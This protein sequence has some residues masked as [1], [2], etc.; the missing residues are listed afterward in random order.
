MSD[1][2]KNISAMIDELES[3]KANLELQLQI[4]QAQDALEEIIPIRLE[5]NLHVFKEK[6]PNVYEFYKDYKPTGKYK[7]FCNEN[8]E[9]NIGIVEDNSSIYGSS[10]FDD[11]RK[12]IENLI[13]RMQLS[14]VSLMKEDDPFHQFHFHIKNQ[15]AD[16]ITSLIQNLPSPKK[17]ESVPFL[18]MFGLGLGY[19]LGYLYERLTPINLFI[20]EPDE[21]LFYCSLCVFDYKSLL[22]YL[23]R[24]HL[25]IHFYLRKDTNSFISNL[26]NYILKHNATILP[27]M[28]SVIYTSKAIEDFLE[29]SQRDF[30]TM[31]F[32]NGFFDD[33]LIGFW[34][35]ITNL[36]NGIPLLL[37][38]K[39]PP[40]VTGKPVVVVGNGPSLD[41]DIDLLAQVQNKC[42][43]IACGTAYSALCKKNIK[44]DIYVAVERTC[45][46]YEALLDIREN[47]DYFMDTICFGLDVVHPN[48]FNMFKNKVMVMKPSETIVT[49]LVKHHYITNR[50]VSLIGRTNPLV[51]NFGVELASL[52]GFKTIYLLGIDNGAVGKVAHSVHS[53]YFDEN[54]N[55][56]PQYSNMVLDNMPLEMP[57]NFVEFCRTSYLFKLSARMTELTITSYRK[58]SSY[59]NCS[60]GIRLEGAEPLHFAEIDWQSASALDKSMLRPILISSITQKINI[61]F[62]SAKEH[63]EISEFHEK[64][65]QIY[66]DWDIK[67]SSRVEFMLREAYQS[68][69]LDV[70]SMLGYV[71]C[72]ALKGSFDLYM[73][74]INSLLY[75]Y[76]DETKGVDVAYS[77][78][79]KY[80]LKF[81]TGC[82]MLYNHILEFET[83][84]QA[85]WTERAID[86]VKDLSP[87]EN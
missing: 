44:A 48:T 73:N 87:D 71:G 51:S 37:N 74:L 36:S 3:V 53:M 2:K 64:M 30:S 67:P 58:D 28:Y 9:A 1:S 38:K 65:W 11:S 82:D 54:H 57:G 56:K 20:V 86:A 69:F 33:I 76:E 84:K 17:F 39:L 35:S 79:R 5:E 77:L 7:I 72:K 45:A 75:S 31:A 10:P 42:I 27:N 52:L 19:H 8:G 66:H 60:N 18:F 12:L 83:S 16:E 55:L 81:F 22:E 21:E 59:F 26:N 62:S 50:E 43:I 61:D 80:L 85:I 78:L 47:R 40:Y 34:H 29:I 70:N 23:Q 41:Q 49:W 46:V 68:E 6:F 25:G 63:L 32:S 14:P 13:D 4:K 24:E 15:M